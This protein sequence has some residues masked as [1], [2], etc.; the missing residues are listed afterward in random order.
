L[1]D[2]IEYHR[3]D[4]KRDWKMDEHDMLR[5]LGQKCRLK[6]KRIYH[7]HTSSKFFALFIQI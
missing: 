7:R 6:I 4:E 2:K 5:V 1:P 3:R